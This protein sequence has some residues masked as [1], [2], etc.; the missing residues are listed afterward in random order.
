MNGCRGMPRSL[1]VVRL[2]RLLLQV[3]VALGLEPD[4][5]AAQEAAKH[6]SFL[7]R[8]ALLDP[9]TLDPATAEAVADILAGAGTGGTG[10]AGAGTGVAGGAGLPG[11]DDA[12]A[13]AVNEL[14]RQLVHQDPNV[15][16]LA[17][18]LRPHAKGRA[19]SLHVSRASPGLFPLFVRG[20]G[21]SI[22]SSRGKLPLSGMATAANPFYDAGVPKYFAAAGAALPP[23]PLASRKVLAAAVWYDLASQNYVAGILEEDDNTRPD[24]QLVKSAPGPGRTFTLYLYDRERNQVRVRCAPCVFCPLTPQ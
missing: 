14:L 1:F 12:A 9:R 11:P 6:N 18:G 21:G 24:L 23:T 3:A 7:P 8:L 13:Q 15:D 10:G 20:D 22:V 19:Q 16:M 17:Y 4:L 2:W 5:A